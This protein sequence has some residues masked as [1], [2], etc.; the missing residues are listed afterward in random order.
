MAQ[1]VLRG[2]TKGYQHHP[3]LD[4]FKNH[5][6]SLEAISVYLKAIYAEAETRGYSFDKT[7]IGPAYKSITLSVTSGQ[8]A[9][10]WKHLLGK[11]Q[12][13]NPSLYRKLQAAETPIPHPIFKVYVGEVESWERV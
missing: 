3:Q 6:A 9:Y 12:T 7:K 8:L 10:E 11:L 1:A 5:S 4:R 13:R 2:D